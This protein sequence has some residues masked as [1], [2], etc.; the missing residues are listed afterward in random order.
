[1]RGRRKEERLRER[2]RSCIKVGKRVIKRG[3]RQRERGERECVQVLNKQRK[4]ER[5]QS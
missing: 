2:E 3:G 1:M 4:K 5:G